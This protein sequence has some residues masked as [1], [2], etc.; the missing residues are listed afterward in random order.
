[1]VRNSDETLH[2]VHAL[3][4]DNPSFNEGQPFADMEMT[5]TFSEP[6]VMVPFKC[7]VHPWMS[8]YAGVVDH[9]FFAVSGADGRFDLE[10][11]PA[12]TYTVEAWHEELGSARRE[13]TVADG[14]RAEI[15]FD[16]TPGQGD[17][18]AD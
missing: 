5:R 10:G 11:L 17:A 7:D 9:P 13:V 8:A 4:V 14:E 12:G 18:A 16:F 3:P 6:E 15:T 2:N 1:V